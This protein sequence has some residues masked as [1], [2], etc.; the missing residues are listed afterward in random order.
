MTHPLS[1]VE[2]AL[3]VNAEF[4]QFISLN[5][6]QFISLSVKISSVY[7]YFYHDKNHFVYI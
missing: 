5:F 3:P 7:K 2:N 6:M 4:I 1:N